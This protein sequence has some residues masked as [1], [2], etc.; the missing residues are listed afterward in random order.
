MKSFIFETMIINENY[1]LRSLNTFG[2]N[3][4]AKYFVEVASV[5]QID[6]AI[7]F[8]KARNVPIL[9]LGGGSNILFTED[10]KG[11]VIKVGLKGIEL[12]SQDDRYYYVKVGA[13]EP[14]DDF[15][16]YCVDHRYA[17]IENLSLVHGTV[18]AAP[19]Q[20]IGAYGVEMKDH[21]HQLEF[22]FFESKTLKI[23]DKQA[24]KFGYRDSIFKRELKGKGMVVSVTFQLLKV[25][26]FNVKYG[27]II[28]EINR[29]GY[30]PISL[31]AI[32]V[33]ISNIRN[34]KLP[35][36]NFIP[37]AGSF[38][39]NPVVSAAKHDQL[40]KEFPGMVSFALINGNF[41]LAAAWLIDQC[42]W[43]G[44]SDGDAG[45]H[46][47]QALVIVNH[48]NATGRDIYDLSE[49]IKIS[50]ALKFGVELEREVN[51]V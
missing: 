45:V 50:V 15:V 27:D 38:F 22:Y 13:G 41:K 9:L 33:A 39:K 1:N 43:K 4:D 19:I 14:W 32:R 21:F 10:F 6:E 49:K 29:I 36:P 25:P 42:G 26:E 34:K 37:N 11:L 16:Q 48:G 47:K 44:K 51:V 20:N 46:D 40:K 31:K 2:I 5:E 30:N 12:I 3:V 8:A 7:A 17:G 35:D 28:E 18:G 23:F 24:C